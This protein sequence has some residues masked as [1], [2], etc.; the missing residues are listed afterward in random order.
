MPELGFISSGVTLTII[1]LGFLIL[2]YLL[3]RIVPKIR[4]IQ[5]L[6]SNLP[7]TTDI[8]EHDDAVIVV[9]PGGRVAYLNDTAKE[10]FDLWKKSPILSGLPDVPDQVICF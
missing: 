2:I 10:W 7:F 1:G 8:P 3:L 6:N 5:K 9:N 4:P